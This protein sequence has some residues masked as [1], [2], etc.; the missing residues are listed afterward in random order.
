MRVATLL[1]GLAVLSIVAAAACKG[2]GDTS[3]SGGYGGYSSCWY[4]CGGDCPCGYGGTSCSE[5]PECWDPGPDCDCACAAGTTTA[6]VCN[7]PAD[8]SFCAGMAPVAGGEC[9][10][11]LTMDCGFTAEDIAGLG[12]T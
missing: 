2:S 7:D 3:G 8:P 4:G 9:E 6:H 12:C 11:A 1:S 10:T 5:D